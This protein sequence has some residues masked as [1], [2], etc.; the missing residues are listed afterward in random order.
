MKFLDMLYGGDCELHLLFYYIH[1]RFE[2][3]KVEINS[4]LNNRKL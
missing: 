4:I 2:E 1:Y 3:M